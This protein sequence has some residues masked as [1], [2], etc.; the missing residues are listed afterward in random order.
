MGREATA[1]VL[2]AGG[3]GGHIF[4]AEALS[5]ALAAQGYTN[6]HLITDQRFSNYASQLMGV[7]VHT[8]RSATLGAGLG[9]KVRSAG[10]MGVG[11][12]Q[13][14]NVLKQLK[15]AVVV[16]FGGYPSVPTVMAAQHMGIPTVIHEQNS[17]AGR[18]NRLLARKAR[19]I[20]V[21]FEHTK[22]FGKGEESRIVYTGNPVRPAV[23]ALRNI[24]YAELR[25]DGI[26]RLLITGGSQGAS[27][28]SQIMPSAIASLPASMRGRIRIDQQCR[29]ADVEVVRAAYQK[30]SVNADLAPF[31]TDLPARL[32]AAHLVICRAGASTVAE[33]MTAGRPAILVP[34]PEAKDNHQAVNAEAIEQIGAGWV[35]PQEGFTA[36]ALAARLESFINLPHVL[37]AASEKAKAQGVVNASEKLLAVLTPYLEAGQSLTAASGEKAA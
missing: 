23:Q 15:P 2:A 7:A 4:P 22:G 16:G 3:T 26:F 35:I 31:F 12:F 24:P 29:L 32:A 10:E 25:D 34:Y 8:I 17:L 5:A 14:R 33:L 9:N 1:I 6:L 18:A 11:Y 19:K 36:Q 28:F 30:L 27:I 20:A 37:A 13:A 21:S